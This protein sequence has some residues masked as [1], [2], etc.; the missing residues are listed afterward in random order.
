MCAAGDDGDRIARATGRRSRC[1]LLSALV[2]V[3]ALWPAAAVL[4]AHWLLDDLSITSA[5][6]NSS[7][8]SALIVAEGHVTAALSGSYLRICVHPTGSAKCYLSRG[9]QIPAA[10]AT[11]AWDLAVSVPA[12]ERNQLYSRLEVTAFASSE[13]NMPVEMSPSQFE[14]ACGSTPRTSRTATV[15]PGS[16]GSSARQPMPLVFAVAVVV[17]LVGIAVQQV[18]SVD[19]PMA[20]II[21][22]VGL[23]PGY[24][25]LSTPVAIA[26]LVA[27]NVA[28]WCLRVRQDRQR[29]Q[30]CR[31]GAADRPPAST[32]TPGKECGQ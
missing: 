24:L 16:P 12:G 21:S 28:L 11:C 26:L 8:G 9:W 22:L 3:A 30:G 7:P 6:W 32:G 20:A 1:W 31:T 13:G 29:D 25:P 17:L 2:V 27:A 10:L 15:V 23:I 5:E 19:A 18:C 14:R 4:R